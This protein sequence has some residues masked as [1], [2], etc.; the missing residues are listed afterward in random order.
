MKRLIRRKGGWLRSV[1][2][3]GIG[4]AIATFVSLLFAPASGKVMR[5]RIT[6][7]TGNLRRLA[8]RGLGRTQRALL[9]QAMLVRDAATEWVT[10]RV[11]SRSN[12]NR[13]GHR[14]GRSRTIRHRV[15]RQ[16]AN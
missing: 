9:Q 1:S 2:A 3:F 12:G 16:R 7:R 8:R 13:N 5:R 14:S 15:A 11:P 6:L 4:A 10:E